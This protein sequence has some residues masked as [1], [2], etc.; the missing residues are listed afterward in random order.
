MS[1]EEQF[2]KGIKFLE[3]DNLD[4]ATKAFERAYKADRDNPKYMSYYGRCA[5]ES[6]GQ[7]GLGLELCTMA[8]KKEFYRPEYYVNLGKVYTA[9]GNKKGAITVIKKGLKYDPENDPLNEMLITLGIRKRAIIPGLKRSNR[10]NR[11]LGVFFRRTLPRLFRRKKAVK[12]K[13]MDVG[14]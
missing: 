5:V 12:E 14:S 1:P 6:W 4:R 8:I 7:I 10:L 9:A 2:K 3:D 11:L 13:Q